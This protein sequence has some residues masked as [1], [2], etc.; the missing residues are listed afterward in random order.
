MLTNSKFVIC[1]Q[2]LN[3]VNRSLQLLTNL[4]NDT[5]FNTSKQMVIH[6]SKIQPILSN[7]TYYQMLNNVNEC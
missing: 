5:N 7:N 6:V 1:Y 3:N 4:T 2:T